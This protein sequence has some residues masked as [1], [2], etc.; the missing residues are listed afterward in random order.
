MELLVKRKELF[1]NCTR[2]EFFIDGR[3]HCYTL[4]DK[5]RNLFQ[6]TPLAIIKE[7]KVYGQTAI[8]LGTYEVKI[9]DSKKFGK[10]MPLVCNVPGFEG[11]RIHKGNTAADTE[12]CVLVG[13]HPVG[14]TGI[15]DCT[16]AFD[17]LFK[18]IEE[19]LKA[20][21]VT[22]HISR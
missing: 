20:G 6:D 9:T 21:P 17:L 19:G 13:M 14:V 1:E 3:R 10:P 16:P 15:F 12:G 8:P 5:D 7:K 2:G 11:I 18:E 4:E 22:I